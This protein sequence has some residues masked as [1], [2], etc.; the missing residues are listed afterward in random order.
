MGLFLVGNYSVL[1]DLQDFP[2]SPPKR[3]DPR[4]INPS[5]AQ[6][7]QE[8]AGWLASPR[9]SRPLPTRTARTRARAPPEPNSHQTLARSA[10]SPARP[11]RLHLRLLGSFVPSPGPGPSLPPPARPARLPHLRRLL[12]SGVQLPAP[13]APPS[14][15]LL[16]AEP[17]AREKKFKSFRC[18]AGL[19]RSGCTTGWSRSH[20]RG[21]RR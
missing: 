19:P 11:A 21:V 1:K 20:H 10:P 2:F 18:C 13:P 5:L 12:P 6:A 17:I 14:F 7:E 4:A 15:H 9:E 8:E 16:G 3:T